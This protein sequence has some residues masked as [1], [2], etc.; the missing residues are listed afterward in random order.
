MTS[1]AFSFVLIDEILSYTVCFNR[2]RIESENSY[3]G[4]GG[5]AVLTPNPRRK[6][7]LFSLTYVSRRITIE[8]VPNT[9]NARTTFNEIISLLVC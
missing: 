6:R 1:H 5:A 8:N 7:H 9:H 4:G 3:R 2:S